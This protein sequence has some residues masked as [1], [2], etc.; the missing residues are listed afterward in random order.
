MELSDVSKAGGNDIFIEIVQSNRSCQVKKIARINKSETKKWSTESE[1]GTC[2]GASFDIDQ[3]EI[4]FRLRTTHGTALW[5]NDFMPKIVTI[6][7][8]RTVFKSQEMNDWI[9]SAKGSM[10]RNAAITKGITYKKKSMKIKLG[11]LVLA[12]LKNKYLFRTQ[13][14]KGW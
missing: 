5:S 10:L 13:R 8:G 4:K 1:L 2:F 6:T 7:I 3:P 9:D 11:E 12:Y 14:T